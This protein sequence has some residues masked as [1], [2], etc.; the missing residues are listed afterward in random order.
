[1]STTRRTVGVYSRERPLGP[2]GERL[3]YNCGGLLPKG[4]PFNCSPKCSEE[5]RCRTSPSYMRIR[6]FQRDMGICSACGLDTEALRKEYKALPNGAPGWY[7]WSS[8]RSP[9]REAFLKR[10]GIPHG[11]VVTDWWDADHIIPVIEGG[12]ECDL[13]NLR[14][15]CIPCHRKETRELHARIKGRRADALRERLESLLA[16]PLGSLTGPEIRELKTLAARFAL[17]SANAV[18]PQAQIEFREEHQTIKP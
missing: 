14:T 2:N 6:L 5:W 8:Y 12:G 15:L 10:N 11:R 13:S 16:R 1:M 7:E 3:C 18:Q 4:R 9:E 17:Q